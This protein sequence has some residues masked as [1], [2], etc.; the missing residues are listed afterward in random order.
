MKRYSPEEL[1]LE[2]IEVEPAERETVEPA[3]SFKDW[4]LKQTALTCDVDSVI[5]QGDAELQEMLMHRNMGWQTCFKGY[6][7]N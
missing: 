7:L 2:L 5:E 1:L 4:A 6:L 3:E